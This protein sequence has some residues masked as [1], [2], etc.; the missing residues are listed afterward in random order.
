MNLF[1]CG[2]ILCIYINQIICD[3]EIIIMYCEIYVGSVNMVEKIFCIYVAQVLNLC[4]INAKMD[5]LL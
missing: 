2:Y 3:S 5:T 1:S 4:H